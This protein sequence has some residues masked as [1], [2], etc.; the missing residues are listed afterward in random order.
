M[1]G[2]VARPPAAQGLVERGQ[3]HQNYRTGFI[4]NQEARV[5]EPSRV[6]KE[7]R[8]DVTLTRVAE[9][10]L[11]RRWHFRVLKSEQE[12]GRPG[13]RVC[14]CV[15]GHQIQ[16]TSRREQSGTGGQGAG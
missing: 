15:C 14:V 13:R 10:N 11:R 3:H 2:D 12:S 6:L 4:L 8:C 7:S 1:R 5:E 9:M 16:E